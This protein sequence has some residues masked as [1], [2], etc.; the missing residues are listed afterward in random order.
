MLIKNIIAS[1][2]A[3]FKTI[4]SR[5]QKCFGEEQEQTILFSLTATLKQFSTE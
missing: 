5:D 2:C 1:E 3:F 4:N